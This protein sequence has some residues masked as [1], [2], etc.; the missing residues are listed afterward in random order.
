MTCDGSGKLGL[1]IPKLIK[2]L[3][4]DP[5][6]SDSTIFAFSINDHLSY[7]GI[8]LSLGEAYHC[9]GKFDNGPLKRF[10]SDVKLL[11]K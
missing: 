4:E 9:A 8:K 3:G 6:C 2:Y 11:P 1:K 7:L 10:L 5:H